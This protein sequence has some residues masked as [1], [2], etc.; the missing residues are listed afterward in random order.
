MSRA[1]PPGYIGST[2]IAEAFGIHPATVRSWILR[3]QIRPPAL[4]MGVA[5]FWTPDVIDE[6]WESFRAKAAVQ[7]AAKVA[8]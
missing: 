3:G 5:N 4:K 8:A 2:E 7:P 1:N 6:L